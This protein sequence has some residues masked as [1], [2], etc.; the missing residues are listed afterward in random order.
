MPPRKVSPKS[1]ILKFTSV[2]TFT[3]LSAKLY[4]T[5][6]IVFTYINAT[7]YSSKF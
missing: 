1:S 5:L 7:F 2:K 3:R 4:F 6:Q